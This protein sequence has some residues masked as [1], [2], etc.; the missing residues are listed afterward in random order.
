MYFHDVFAE[1]GLKCKDNANTQLK[2]SKYHT[3][4][5]KSKS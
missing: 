2:R 1:L 3:M 4:F 5:K